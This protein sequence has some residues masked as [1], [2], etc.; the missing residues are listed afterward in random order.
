MTKTQTNLKKALLITPSLINSWLYIWQCRDGVKEYE[1]DEMC[2]ED[3]KDKASE[4]ARE[5]FLNY[6]NRL[7]SEP[8]EYMLRGIQ[9]EQDC[10]DGKTEVSPIIEGG[11]FQIAGSKRVVVDGQPFLMYGRLDVLKGGTIYDIKRVSRYSLPKYAKSAQHRFYLDLFPRA[12]KFT[13]L[14]Y[15]G[16]KLHTETYYREQCVPTESL[17]HQFMSWLKANGLFEIYEEKWKAKGE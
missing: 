2:L 13:Y 10:Y 16:A 11:A 15:D 17:I 12:N 1:K 6:L 14:I 4:E 5:E 3:K 9:F 7:P 8:N